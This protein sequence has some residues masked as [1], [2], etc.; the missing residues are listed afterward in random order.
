MRFFKSNQPMSVEDEAAAVRL[1]AVASRTKAA[2]TTR[3][4]FGD[5]VAAEQS[6]YDPLEL[7]D[8]LQ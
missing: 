7:K 4:T 3:P 1:A 8:V 6:E 5:A 2:K